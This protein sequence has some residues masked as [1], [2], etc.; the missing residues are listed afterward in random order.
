DESVYDAEKFMWI[1][2]H[3]L[4]VQRTLS[5]AAEE[6][7]LAGGG[8]PSMAPY[9]VFSDCFS[10]MGAAAYYRACGRKD[11]KQE[12]LSAFRSYLDREDRPKGEW[13]KGLPGRKPMKNRGFYMMI[14]KLPY[15]RIFLSGTL[16]AALPKGSSMNNL[17][18]LEPLAQIG[19]SLGCDC[20]APNPPPAN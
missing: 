5:Q 12:A 15:S 1:Q 20:V 10:V 2:W 8:S 11:A 6:R 13:I 3:R 19:A 16:F 7:A 17:T 18:N 4:D 14:A 9:S